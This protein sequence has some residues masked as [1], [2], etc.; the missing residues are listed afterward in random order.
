MKDL[1]FVTWF[2]LLISEEFSKPF[3]I[4]LFPVTHHLVSHLLKYLKKKERSV[5]MYIANHSDSKRKQKNEKYGNYK[6]EV[7]PPVKKCIFYHV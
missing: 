5:V 3:R 4:S 1:D 2:H 6:I 7:S